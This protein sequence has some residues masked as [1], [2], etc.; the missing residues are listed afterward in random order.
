MRQ[1]YRKHIHHHVV[2][3]G[4]TRLI[5]GGVAL[6][7]VGV[8]VG[9]AASGPSADNTPIVKAP[10]AVELRSIADLAADQPALPL[11][12]TVK[13]Q[14]QATIRTQSQGEVIGVYRKLGDYVSAGAVIAELQNARE[15]ASVLQAQAGL[16]A[17]EASYQKVTG[18]ARSE[19][20][21]ILQISAD[22]ARDSLNSAKNAT[23]AALLSAYASADDAVRKKTDEVLSSAD[24]STPK[25]NFPVS[26]SQLRFTIESTRVTIKQILDRQIAAAVTL[27]V[28]TDLKA[29]LSKTQGEM[30]II[31]NYLDTI[32]AATNSAIPTPTV[33]EATI[34]GYK[35]N[36]GA[37]RTEVSGTLSSLSGASEN[38]NGKTA[39]LD[40]ALKN[41][42]QG[43][44]GGQ[45]EDVTSAQAQVT[46]SQ[47][48]VAAALA[49]LENTIIRA[50]ISGTINQLSLERGDFVSAFTPVVTVANNGALEV[51]AFV[52]E[53]ERASIVAGAAA[54]IEGKLAGTVTRVAPAIDPVSKKVEVHVGVTTADASLTNGQSVSLSITRTIK[55]V[56][57]VNE[58]TIPLSALKVLTDGVAVYTVDSSNRLVAHMVTLGPILGDKVVIRTGVTSD[59][60]IV[61]DARGLK[62]GD[63]VTI[64]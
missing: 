63:E 59:M 64:K 50:P 61:L 36:A 30:R 27:S 25:L 9:F 46:Q 2:R 45:S 5:L 37:A 48:L 51:V 53:N 26:D 24:S 20:R 56:A 13:S 8:A 55:A 39:A 28:D 23:V 35:T 43:V 32:V 12:G 42:E 22:N 62:E 60:L 31:Y 18:G 40:I 16:N 34:A 29:E 52:T 33:T 41:Q 1:I 14:S 10:R 6:L 4:L 57:D 49:N 15:R 11:V 54:T 38:L 17:A 58:T 47:A 19:Q 7:L 3:I 44:A 21:S